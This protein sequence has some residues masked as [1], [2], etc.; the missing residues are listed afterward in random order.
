M[1]PIF[2]IFGA[3]AFLLTGPF[4]RVHAASVP[5]QTETGLKPRYSGSLSPPTQ[6]Q[7]PSGPPYMPNGPQ[8]CSEYRYVCPLD[9]EG[10]EDLFTCKSTL[11]EASEM[12]CV[13]L[14]LVDE[15]VPAI[16]D[17]TGLSC[18]YDLVTGD[19]LP[20]ETDDILSLCPKKA[21]RECKSNMKRALNDRM[22]K[23]RFEKGQVGLNRRGVQKEFA[24][25]FEYSLVLCSR[26]NQYLLRVLMILSVIGGRA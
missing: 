11:V 22:H 8:G 23:R 19:L 20:V 16:L 24:E 3:L 25:E 15:V 18:A 13:Y 17:I 9:I 4:F 10:D 21:V 12:V 5:S 1:F 6:Q 14:P 7:P 2:L 26:N